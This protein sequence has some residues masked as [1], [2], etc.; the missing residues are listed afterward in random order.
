M[1]AW[2]AGRLHHCE[3][4]VGEVHRELL[5]YPPTT[6]RPPGPVLLAFHGAGSC[7]AAMVSF[8]GLNKAAD[9]HG[10]TV[11]YPQG[12]G[13]TATT[14]SW[15]APGANVYAVRKQ[16]DDVGF[17]QA[18]LGWLAERLAYDPSRV[19]ATGMSNGGL[20]CYHLALQV[21]YLIAGIAPVAVAMTTIPDTLPSDLPP[22][23]VVHLHGTA[24][25]FVRYEG[26]LGHQSLTRTR[27]APVEDT[28]RFWAR[29]NACDMH[30]VLT[31]LT[32]Q[33]ADGTHVTRHEY[34]GGRAPVV[35]YQIHGGGHT[36]PGELSNYAFL[37]EVSRNLLANET[38]WQFLRTNTR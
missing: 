23:P 7:A 3:L 35:L 27:F 16:V 18:L 34:R 11:V 21:P 36:W 28:V 17:V 9:R 32:P 20:F 33:V 25:H 12:S 31:P 19:Y 10:F 37:G 2:E 4:L 13:R 29:V 24:D 15:N 1:T 14:C 22:L 26:G 30:P 6:Y 5:V 38:I 8:C